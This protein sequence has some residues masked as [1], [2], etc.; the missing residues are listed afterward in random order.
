MQRRTGSILA[1]RRAF[2]LT[3]LLVVV[4]II[5]LLLGTLFVAINAA[6]KRAQVAKTQF[7]M[8]TIASGLAQFNTDFGYHPPVLGKRDPSPG[9]SGFARDVVRYNDNVVGGGN[10]LARQQNWASYTTLA[11]YLLGYGHRGEDGYGVQR[12]PANGQPYPATGPQN[13]GGLMPKEAPPFGIRSPGPDGCWG[14]IDAPPAGF[15]NFRG[16]YRAR[17]PMRT[18]GAP[19]V[20]SNLWNR[21]IFEG[22]VY[23]PYIDSM[24]ERLIGGLTGFDSQG[25]PTVVTSD[26]IPPSQN[27]NQ[28]TFDQLPKVILD[29]WGNPIAYYRAPYG[30]DDL[31]SNVPSPAGGF[32]N[33]GDIFCLREWEID[34]AEQSLGAADA[35]GDTSSSAA[36]KAA[37]FALFSPG[38]DR[39]FNRAVRRDVDEFNKDNVIQAA[40]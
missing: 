4:A 17:N 40:K 16:Y 1:P 21:E 32:L 18:S 37:S 31:K 5:V 14:A 25:R 10:D 8:N 6:S 19:A 39:T 27:S 7:L 38:A 33:L 22:R 11:E 15:A 36:M 20:T 3:E 30:G 24:D 35:N 12:D 26:Q 9:T 29:Y 2:T 28:P 34:T 13:P 23:G